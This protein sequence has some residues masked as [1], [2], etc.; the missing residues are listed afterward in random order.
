MIP[1]QWS[2]A[3]RLKRWCVNS[4]ALFVI[5]HP[6]LF[7]E[8]SGVLGSEIGSIVN[9]RISEQI[10]TSLFEGIMLV[11]MLLCIYNVINLS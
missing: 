4:P 5:C 10:A 3:D 2:Q 6:G 9:R 1:L 11:V 8:P 7:H